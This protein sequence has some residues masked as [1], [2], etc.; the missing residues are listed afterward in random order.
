MGSCL[1]SS[2]DSSLDIQ[3]AGFNLVIHTYMHTY[4]HTYIHTNSKFW[5]THKSRNSVLFFHRRSFVFKLAKNRP[6]KWNRGTLGM[7]FPL[8]AF[9][10]KCMIAR[11][12]K[13]AGLKAFLEAVFAKTN[14]FHALFLFLL[15][16]L[17]WCDL[18]FALLFFAL[19]PLRAVLE[20]GRTG[21]R[22]ERIR[23]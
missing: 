18:W 22:R 21:K 6:N 5:P 19:L 15:P 1:A 17:F 12:L 14:E 8:T 16:H 3:V 10:T 23:P 9:L 13:S 2:S 20:S 7:K 4:I 11:A